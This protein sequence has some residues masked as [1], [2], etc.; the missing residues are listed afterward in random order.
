MS[1]RHLKLK[2]YNENPKP[3]QQAKAQ[4]QSVKEEIECI[5]LAK[6]NEL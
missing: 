1:L 3:A 4:S 6:N 5:N 2:S